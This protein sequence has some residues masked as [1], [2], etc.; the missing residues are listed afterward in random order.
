[1]SAKEY[2]ATHPK[3]KRTRY[4]GDYR[5][6]ERKQLIQPCT[7]FGSKILVEEGTDNREY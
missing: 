1:M 4:Y 5:D 6:K 3:K 2:W 7:C